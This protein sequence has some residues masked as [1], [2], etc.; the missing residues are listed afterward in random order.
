M[1]SALLPVRSLL[2][3]IFMMMAGSGFLAT[4]ISVRL[5]RADVDAPLIGVVG[6]AYFAG[7]TAGSL[8]VA[9]LIARVGH[10]R[11]FSAFLSIFSAS[12]L[13]YALYRHPL[14][15]AALRFVDGFMV[16][17]MFICLESWLNDQAE[18]RNRGT[19][20]A[21]YMIALYSGQGVGQYLLNLGDG[22]PSLPFMAAAIL[23]SL[24]LVPVAL[25]RM[26]QPVVDDLNPMSLPRLYDASPLG[27]AGAS[28]TGVMLG[29]FYALGA[30]YVGRLGMTLSTTA[31]FMSLVILGGVLLQWP[32]GWLSDRIDRRKVI[33]ASFA[34]AF[35]I[36]AVIAVTGRTG[37][38]LMVLGAAF[39]GVS[40][41]LYPLCV[42]HT[43]D[44]LDPSERVGASGGLVLAYSLGAVAGPLGGSA[45]MALLGAPGL[46]LFI[47]AC[48]LAMTLFG[49]W[50]Q[51]AMPPVPADEQ[52]AFQTLPRTTPMVGAFDPDDGESGAEAGA[53]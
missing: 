6:A 23:L 43:N 32:L 45:A 34:A 26:A 5:E 1:L 11:A 21:G 39:G 36:C 47:A 50:R 41:A 12:M 18:P 35:L 24:A 16:A 9:P 40:F 46:F 52:N 20:L 51:I 28:A 10:I 15:W 37:P 38:H 14:L 8:R 42:A 22:Q 44:R 19:V 27:V 3:A 7:L 49:M 17:G 25:T 13:A 31:L 30:V 48:A 29:A 2:I 4:L 53:R 33:I